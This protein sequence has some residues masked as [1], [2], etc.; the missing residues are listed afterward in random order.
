[1]FVKVYYKSIS[2]DDGCRYSPLSAPV[3]RTC[4]KSQR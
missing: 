1:M 4:S 3:G 2:V